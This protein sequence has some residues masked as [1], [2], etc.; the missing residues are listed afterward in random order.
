MDDGDRKKNGLAVSPSLTDRRSGSAP[1]RSP[2]AVLKS[3]SVL[4][5][6]PTSTD[7]SV[8]SAQNRWRA[9]GYRYG[10]GRLKFESTSLELPD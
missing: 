5:Y 2:S 9:A 1:Q 8:G 4:D 6:P 3:L 7:G 10:T